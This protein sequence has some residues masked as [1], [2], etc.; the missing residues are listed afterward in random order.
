MTTHTLELLS[1]PWLPA[2]LLALGFPLL[3]LLLTELI[4]SGAR[5]KWAITPTLRAVR[6]TL[7][8]ALGAMLFVTEVWQMPV[9]STVVRAVKT[10]FWLAALY[11]IL[12]LIN[13]T[14]FGA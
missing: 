6:N 8:P 12:T 11:S 13:D 4:N 14:I 10:L 3:L 5:R 7:I 2:I 9:D 1:I